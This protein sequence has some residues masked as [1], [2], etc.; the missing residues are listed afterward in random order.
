M[1]IFTKIFSILLLTILTTAFTMGKTNHGDSL[2]NSWNVQTLNPLLQQKMINSTWKP[3]CPVPL[4]N[5]RLIQVK[6]YDFKKKQQLGQLIAHKDIA[7]ELLTIFKQLYQKKILIHKIKPLHHYKGDDRKSM[8]DNITSIFNC[9][10]NTMNPKKFSVHS[11]G[12]AIDINPF[13]NPL[14][15]KRKKTIKIKPKEAKHFV[16]RTK[17]TIGMIH[18]NSTIWN[19]FTSNNWQWGGTWRRVQDYQHFQKRD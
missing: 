4:K 14:V 10:Q 1:K 19:I 16:N 5:L 7:Q 12:K 17:K 9:R 15:Y 3:N 13:Q 6:H 2:N 11:Y 8:I 18:R